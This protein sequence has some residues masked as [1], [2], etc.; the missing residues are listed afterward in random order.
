MKPSVFQAIQTHYGDHYRRVHT[1]SMMNTIS[2]QIENQIIQ[3]RLG[4]EMLV[5]FQRFSAFY[6]QTLRYQALAAVCKRIVVFGIADMPPPTLAGIEFVEIDPA[7]PLADEWFLH[8]NS[9]KFWTLLS[10]QQTER[11]DAITGAR[12]YDAVWTFDELAVERASMTFSALLKTAY[13]PI[14]RRDHETQAYHIAQ[15]N[16]ILIGAFETTR[17]SNLRHWKHFQ[18]INRVTRAVSSQAYLLDVLNE[19]ADILREV[20]G[21]GQVGVAL[22]MGEHYELVVSNGLAQ[23]SGTLI[24]LQGNALGAALASGELMALHGDPLLPAARRILAVPLQGA[25][26]LHGSLIVGRITPGDWS[27]DEMEMLKNVAELMVT[28]VVSKTQSDDTPTPIDAEQLESLRSSVAYLM[29]LQQRLDSE[30]ELNAMQRQTLD[31]IVK[32]SFNLARAVGIREE[33][34]ARI[35]QSVPN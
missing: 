26:G 4:V 29:A 33:L 22:N 24:A 7:S 2:H 16:E 9:P 13:A 31:Q 1:V 34:A 30:G 10:A 28:A 23:P 18:T 8:V 20:A 27:P 15:M 12:G 6:P 21:I 19:T 35:L 17:I 5:G 25:H 14:F 32:L 3:H 11:L